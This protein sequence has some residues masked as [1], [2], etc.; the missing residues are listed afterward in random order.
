MLKLTSLRKSNCFIQSHLVEKKKK[1]EKKR[2]KYGATKSETELP[3]SQLRGTLGFCSVLGGHC[4]GKETFHWKMVRP[5]SKGT[6][7][8]VAVVWRMSFR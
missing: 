1:E 7:D 6:A 2:K 3:S 5:N 8:L 4:A